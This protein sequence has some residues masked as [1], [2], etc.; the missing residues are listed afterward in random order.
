MKAVM[1]IWGYPDDVQSVDCEYGEPQ[2]M[3]HL[4]SCRLQDEA[5][6]ARA[7]ETPLARA[8]EM[9][10]SRV[11]EMPSARAIEMPAS[12]AVEM[13]SARA[14]DTPASRATETPFAR[15]IEMPSARAI[16]TPSAQAIEMPSA[17]AIETPSSPLVPLRRH[18]FFFR[19]PSS[20]IVNSVCWSHALVNGP[21]SKGPASDGG[22]YSGQLLMM[23]S[24]I[25]SGSPHSHVA[26]SA[27]PH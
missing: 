15:A 19:I 4:L 9:P 26:F 16:E 11:I 5:P 20:Q 18:F 17:H 24:A 12:R 1:R 27:S 10:A 7:S 3:A 6:S 8:I 14:I 22:R 2:M 13:P 23:W 25:C 21:T